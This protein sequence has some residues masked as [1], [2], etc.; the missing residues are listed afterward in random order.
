MIDKKLARRLWDMSTKYILE[1]RKDI[2][3]ENPIQEYDGKLSTIDRELK[4]RYDF[5]GDKVALRGLQR[6]NNEFLYRT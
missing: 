3:K 1:L 2:Q 5:H 6:I 4:Y